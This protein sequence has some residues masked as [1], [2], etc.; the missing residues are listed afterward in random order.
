MARSVA[1]VPAELVEA[2]AVAVTDDGLPVMDSGLMRL[3]LEQA[4]LA[5]GYLIG[6]VPKNFDVSARLGREPFFVVEADEYDTA[7]F[8]KRSKF[9]HYRPRT[10]VLNNLE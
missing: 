4:D 9:V 3:A 8:D 10:V 1:A 7:F 2:G 5:P 6:G